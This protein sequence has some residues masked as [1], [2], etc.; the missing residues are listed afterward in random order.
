VECV[1][2]YIL[3]PLFHLTLLHLQ[4]HAINVLMLSPFCGR[5]VPKYSL[6]ATS[7]MFAV[8]QQ[9][10]GLVLLS[11]EI[12]VFGKDPEQVMFAGPLPT[13]RTGMTFLYFLSFL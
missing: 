2:L 9:C 3:K 12:T 10:L 6:C 4:K 5:K 1:K 11:E 8:M 7:P 13:V